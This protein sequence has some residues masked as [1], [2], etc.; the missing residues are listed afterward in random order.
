MAGD[1]ANPVPEAA[2]KGGAGLKVVK[3]EGKPGEKP[4]AKAGMK[5]CKGCKKWF[6]PALSKKPSSF[7]AEDDKALDRIYLMACNNGPEDKKW[8][9]EVRRDEDKVSELLDNYWSAVGGKAKWAGKTGTGMKF[10]LTNYKEMV[11]ATSGVESRRKG[12]HDLTWD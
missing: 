3:A 5:K 8:L 10:N 4:K 11:T 7:C 1:A 6:D 12:N 9:A 2:K